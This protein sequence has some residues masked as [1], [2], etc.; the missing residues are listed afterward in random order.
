MAETAESTT[1]TDEAIIGRIARGDRAAFSLLYDRFSPPLFGLLKQILSDEKDAEDVLQESFVY[2]WQHA[3]QYDRTKSK[4]FTWAVM[5]FRHKAIDRLRALGR[6]ERLNET[7]A[8][9]IPLLSNSSPGADEEAHANDR[10]R[11][12]REALLALP[13]EQ[14][15]LIEFAY[16]KGLT[17]HSIAESLGIPLGTVKTSIRRGLLKLRDLLKGGAQ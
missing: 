10:S 1:E 6:R 11:M 13:E 5:I 7:A 12:V 14:R 9:E 17:H 8:T 2:V 15:K 3:A 16:L 4:A